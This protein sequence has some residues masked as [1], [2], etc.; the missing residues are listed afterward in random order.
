MRFSVLASGSKG[1]MTYIQ[2][3]QTRLLV[4]AGISFKEANLRIDIDF[5]SIDAIL[6]THEHHDHVCGLITMA[7]R[8]GATIYVQED[9]YNALKRKYK[10][11]LIGLKVCIIEANKKYQINDVRFLTLRLSHDSVSCLGFIFVDDEGSLAYITDTGFLPIPYIEL[12]KKVDALII[13]ANHDVELLH[14]SNRP[15]M[16]KERILSVSGHM[17]NYISGQVINTVLESKKLKVLVLAHLSEECNTEE[18]AIDT[19]LEAIEGDYLPQML[20]ARQ[21]MPTP[22]IEVCNG[23]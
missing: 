14:N 17:S 15:W 19:I 21:T 5:S 22:I 12:L 18:L 16:L 1:N 7:K 23:D 4:D 9:T 13:E 2:T 6:I 8:S 10:E 20:V 11:K 3:P